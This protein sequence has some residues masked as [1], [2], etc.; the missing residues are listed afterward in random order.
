MSTAEFVGQLEYT[1]FHNSQACY[2]VIRHWIFY[3]ITV[4]KTFLKDINLAWRSLDELLNSFWQSRSTGS[5]SVRRHFCS[6]YLLLNFLSFQKRISL[7]CSTN[8]PVLYI[9]V[10]ICFYKGRQIFSSQATT[11]SELLER[12]SQLG[13]KDHH[14]ISLLLTRIPLQQI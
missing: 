5:H 14:T 8:L 7:L 10:D 9:P 3:M 4:S 11:F 2:N 1:V 6:C 13:T 12:Y